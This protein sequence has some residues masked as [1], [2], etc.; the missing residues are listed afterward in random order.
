MPLCFSR[1]AVPDAWGIDDGYLDAAGREQLV[2]PS[3]RARLRTIMG[4]APIARP[5]VVVVRPGDRVRVGAG[6]LSLENGRSVAVDGVLPRDLPDGYHDFVDGEGNHIRVIVTPGRCP[7]P[8]RQSWG[9]AVQLYAAR[10]P[11]SWG[12]GDLADLRRLAAW[13]RPRGAGFMLVNPISAVAPTL[14]Q[15]PSPYFPAT[16]RFRNPLYLHIEDIPGADLAAAQVERAAAAGKE[17][18]TRREIDRDA[19]SRLKGAAL[20]AI[21]GNDAPGREFERW[22]ADH[23]DRVRLFAAWS[24]LAEQ[25]GP[26]WRNWPADCRRP[27]GSGVAAIIAS[28]ADRIRFH[29][30]LQW[31]CGSQFD[32]AGNL[33][34]LVQDLPVGFDPDGFDAW[35]W[36]DLL[37]LDVSVGAPPDEFNRQGQNWGLPPFVPWRLAESGYQPFIETIRAVMHPGG[38]LRLDHVMGLFRLWWIPEGSSAAEGA[39]VRYPSEDLLGIVALESQRSHALVV[40]EDLGTVEPSAR[41]ALARHD[42]LSYR[43]L[44]FENAE[45]REW[46]TRALAAVTTHDLPTVA[47]LWGGTDLSEQRRL[48]LEPNVEATQ[49]I[50]DR[51]RRD[52]GLDDDAPAEEAVV[53]AYQLLAGAPSRLLA[54]TLEDAVGEAERPNIPGT[55]CT[56]PNWSLALS[57]PID[58]LEDHP[59]A[60]RVEAALDAATRSVA[61]TEPEPT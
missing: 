22:Y 1:P 23:A 40:G 21:W 9:W 10:S 33:I 46:P 59:L 55:E 39:Y 28:S 14:P 42:L 15:Q 8:A 16:R 31:L 49:A 35:E 58:E 6:D 52:G 36:Q 11:A 30:W 20:E 12:M 54:A 3:S 32:A 44:W 48:G 51:L 25:H 60:I 5:G 19:V 27:D 61:T 26:R 29:A 41:P 53:A 38:G 7:L 57:V 17:L 50:R 37:A 18:N 43:L 24:V 13:S 56:R 45:P 34:A 2:S 4:P 47:G